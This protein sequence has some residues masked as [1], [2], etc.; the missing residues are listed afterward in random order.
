MQRVSRGSASFSKFWHP[1]G[2]NAAVMRSKCHRGS[3]LPPDTRV[4][5]GRRGIKERAGSGIGLNTNPVAKPLWASHSLAD[6]LEP[7]RVVS[8][9]GWAL[10]AQAEGHLLPAGVLHSWLP[11]WRRA[12]HCPTS[13]IHCR[14]LSGVSPGVERVGLCGE[15]VGLRP[16]A[17]PDTWFLNFWEFAWGRLAKCRACHNSPYARA[18]IEKGRA[19]RAGEAQR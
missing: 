4:G 9:G 7:G 1:S 17:T 8:C 3:L 12:D 19:G 16:P 14:K 13:S 5:E 10:I 18:R 11:A 2:Q 6:P 15:R